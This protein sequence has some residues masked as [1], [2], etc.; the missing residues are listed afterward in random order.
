VLWDFLD[1]ISEQGAFIGS[2]N[3][4]QL[5]RALVEALDP[6]SSISDY[7]RYHPWQDDGGYLRKL[8]STCRECCLAL[9]SYR[10]VQPLVLAGV[11]QC[12]VQAIN[13]VPDRLE[14][15][16][17]L[18]AW[19]ERQRPAHHQLH[20]FEYAAATSAFL[21]HPLLALAAEPLHD[22]Q[23]AQQAQAA[24]FP[25]MALAITMLDSYVDTAEDRAGGKHSYISH[26]TD[27][28]HMCERLREILTLTLK[29]IATLPRGRRHVLM[30]ASMTAMYLSTSAGGESDV[31]ALTN[32]IAL[33][34][35]SLTRLLLPVVRLWRALDRPRTSPSYRPRKIVVPGVA[36]M[37]VPAA[38]QTF[39]FWRYPFQTLQN[40]RARYGPRFALN[41]TSQPP[42][43]FLSDP[44]EIRCVIAAPQ[45]TLHPGEG[46]AAVCPIV[47][48]GSF[49]LSDGAEHAQGRKTVVACLR[50]H[51]VEEHSGAVIEAARQ[52]VASWPTDQTV[53]LHPRL[54]SLTLEVILRTLTGSFDGS[55]DARLLQLHD[56]VLKMLAVTANPMF[57][58]PRLRHGPG[59]RTW[60]RFLRDRAQVDELLL[61]LIDKQSP[62]PQS[63]PLG[64]LASLCNSDGSQPPRGQVRD[65]VMS[66]ILAGHE[67]TAAQLAWAFQLLAHNPTACERLHREIDE[68]NGE[69]YLTATI[70]EVLRHRCAFIFAIPR[71]V[72]EPIVVG[73]QTYYPPA[74]LLACIYLLHH[75]PKTYP[76]PHVFRPER[77]LDSP[78]DPRSW[79]PWG[80]GRRRCPGLHLAMLEMKIVLRTVLATRTVH[81]ADRQIERPR[82]R[83]VIVAPDA[84]SRVILRPR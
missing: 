28:E 67:T 47:G 75:D 32:R 22:T 82:W 78:P 81:P 16:Q 53:S 40:C 2:K 83:S 65:N 59:R 48:E 73:G 57:I 37:P 9:P 23:Y 71:A 38:V 50:R 1:D 21:P 52:A 49:M 39:L 41:A 7:Y 19:A 12:A 15:E 45:Q 30:G 64:T 51:I 17:E 6:T 79:M 61:E 46:G 10:Q 36:Q 70:Q 77:F 4:Y 55:P 80:G 68:G 60:Q 3:G 14:R 20:W 18:R 27:Q 34:G 35:G 62:R 8:V 5:H 56:R 44:E 63:D 84:G 29:A 26:Y 76:E 25:W 74:H 33:G 66:L 42:L 43:I 69:E 58:E 11:R 72:V 24:Y 31:L 54:R 13:H